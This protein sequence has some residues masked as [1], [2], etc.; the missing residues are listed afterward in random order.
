MNRKKILIA[1]FGDTGALAAIHL[2]KTYEITAVSTKPLL[3]S[4]Q[5]LGVRITDPRRWQKDYQIA[6]S[7]YKNLDGVNIVHGEVIKLYPHE[8]RTQVRESGGKVVEYHYDALLIASGVK[9]GFWRNGEVETRESIETSLLEVSGKLASEESLAVIGGGPT[10]VSAAYNFKRQYPGKRVSLYFPGSAILRNYPDKTR[11]TITTMLLEQGVE[12]KPG[13]RAVC[14]DN[15]EAITQGET[16][17]WKTGQAAIQP[18]MCLWAVG[19][20]KPNSGFLP[21]EMLD[22]NGFVGVDEFLR[23]QGYN[24]IFAVGDI[25][26]SD[27]NRSSA[28]NEGFKLVA[29]NID[30]SLNS[31]EEVMKVFKAPK[32]RWG[33][34]LGVQ[35]D[36]GLR[37]FTPTGGNYRIGVWW[38]KNVLFPFF[39]RR[40]IYKG[41]RAE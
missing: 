20:L 7:R 32:Y 22:K 13:H 24:N 30:C 28:R 27:P 39:V 40:L 6:F 10:A 2:P 12:L 25:A 31:N 33:S 19:Q 1:G 11:S 26:N 9:N 21:E 8:N 35:P 16:V 5:E 36:E 4:G 3:L 41:V 18:D 37:V 17:E 14:P 23:V 38:V 29:Y 15:I 34:I